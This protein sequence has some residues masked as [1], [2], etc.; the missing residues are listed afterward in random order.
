LVVSLLLP[1]VL[2]MEMCLEPNTI[3]ESLQAFI[4][5]EVRLADTEYALCRV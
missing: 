1:Q 5:V 3:A 2:P 4:N